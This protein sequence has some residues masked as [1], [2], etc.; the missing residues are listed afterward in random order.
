MFDRLNLAMLRV[1][2]SLSTPEA[3]RARVQRQRVQ[4]VVLFVLI[5]AYGALRYRSMNAK[6]AWVV[7]VGL[8]LFIVAVQ[9]YYANRRLAAID[10]STE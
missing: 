2:E 4:S 3:R 8:M 1:E 5:A 7:F 10:R 9:A 6:F